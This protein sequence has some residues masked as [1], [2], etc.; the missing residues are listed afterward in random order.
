MKIRFIALTGKRG[1]DKKEFAFKYGSKIKLFY[2]ALWFFA[3]QIS[4]GKRPIDVY[5]E[6]KSITESITR[7]IKE[8]ADRKCL[9]CGLPLIQ[10]ALNQK[11]VFHRECRKAGRRQQRKQEK[12]RRKNAQKT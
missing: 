8:A 7:K 1:F 9:Y 6:V 10:T 4:F 5:E 12:E 11:I 2:I 3:I